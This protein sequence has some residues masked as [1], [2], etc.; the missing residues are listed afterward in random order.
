MHK[1]ISNVSYVQNGSKTLMYLTSVKKN[2]DELYGV[3]NKVAGKFHEVLYDQ[4]FAI[5]DIQHRNQSM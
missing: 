5:Q 4:A 2:S 1:E 3:E